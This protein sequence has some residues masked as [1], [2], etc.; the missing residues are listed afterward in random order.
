MSHFPFGLVAKVAPTLAI[1][2]AIMRTP[3]V[4]IALILLLG[5]GVAISA[6]SN[7]SGS[8]PASFEIEVVFTDEEIRII[9]AHYRSQIGNEQKGNGKQKHKDLPPGIEKNLARGKPLPPG[10]AKKA[11]PSDLVRRLPPVQDGYE[12]IIVA[13]KI[14]LIE[15]ATQAVRDVLSDA[16]FD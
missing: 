2:G 5:S 15:I 3:V 7:S 12:R 9:H 8:L 14:L 10:I 16:L 13:G 11:L 1:I 6:D 4:P